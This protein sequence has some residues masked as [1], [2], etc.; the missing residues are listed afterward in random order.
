MI[1]K[2]TSISI[3][4]ADDDVAWLDQQ[5]ERMRGSNPKWDRSK[6]IRSAILHHRLSKLPPE[7]QAKI[8]KLLGETDVEGRL[9]SENCKLRNEE[10][11]EGEGETDLTAEDAEDAEEEGGGEECR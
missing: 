5:V 6:Q 10:S 7:Q 3:R 9:G 4:L 1:K 2:G 11:A 8:R